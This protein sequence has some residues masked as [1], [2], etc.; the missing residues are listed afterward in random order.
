MYK[1]QFNQDEILNT[2]FFNNKKNGRFLDVGA[3]DGVKGSNSYFFEKEL[4]WTGLCFEPI[5]ECFDE[6]VKVRPNSTC[7]NKCAYSSNTTVKFNRVEGYAE[8]LSGIVDKYDERHQTRIN[9][10]IETQ[11]GKQTILECDAVTITS[12][13]ESLDPNICDPYHYDFM[14]LDVEGGEYDVLQGIDF[15]KIK[16]DVIT[17]ENNYPDKFENV[18]KFLLEKG[19]KFV[20]N[21]CIDLIFVHS[22][23]PYTFK[24]HIIGQWATPNDIKKQ[25]Q[26]MSEDGNGSWGNIQ[27]VDQSIDPDY[28]VVLNY[29]NYITQE[30]ANKL[31]QQPHKII[32][33]H[34]EPSIF[35]SQFGFFANPPENVFKFRGV[36]SKERNPVCWEIGLKYSDLLTS[37]FT[38]NKISPRLESDRTRSEMSAIVSS[39]YN[40]PG[41]KLRID[42]LKFI[43]KNHPEFKF[44]LYGKSNDHSFSNYIAPLPFLKKEQGLIPYKYT[45]NSE[46]S[47]EYNYATE[48]IYDAILCE[49][50]CF[51][52]GCPN[53]EDYIDPE[54]FIRLDFNDFEKSFKI[55]QNAIQN[56]E[57]ERRLPAIKRMKYRILTELQFF[58]RV[59]N[60][61]NM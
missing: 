31:L 44:D 53:L 21:A 52:W 8:T 54:C 30:Y 61:I 33:F 17:I 5:K 39:L 59:K 2:K 29:P 26:I 27:V 22:S 6:L 36:H 60:I 18:F 42:F 45:F 47:S 34:M 16:I 11:G 35:S 4:G 41:H 51:Y 13:C 38:F 3:H 9:S 43:E 24:V 10:E 7:I 58:N 1:S 46:N 14:S 49:C 15:S 56:G 23:F 48:K 32:F 55:I 37:D 40:W 57:W 50:L 28:Y 12:I 20:G 25:F 19:Y